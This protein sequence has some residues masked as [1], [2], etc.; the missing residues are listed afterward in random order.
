MSHSEH[1][2]LIQI[3]KL[4]EEGK[5]EKAL[6]LLNEFGK[7]E[8]L[9]HRERIAYYRLKSLVANYFLDRNECRKYA[10]KAYQESKKLENSLL[11]LDVYIQMGTALLWNFKTSEAS[12][13][14]KKSEDLLKTLPQEFSTELRKRKAYILW[15]K[16]IYY[17]QKGDLEKGIEYREDSLAILEE[18]DLKIDI[19]FVLFQLG[20]VSLQS[21]DFNHALEY[22]ES[23]EILFTNLNLI[24]FL[25]R[26]YQLYGFIYGMKGELDRAL[27]YNEKVMA[28]AEKEND[29]D[30]RLSMY[31]SSG[32]LYQQKGD[33][34]HALKFL[35]KSITIAEE[36]G[37]TSHKFAVNDSLFYLA[38]EMNDLEQAQ[39][40]LNRMK[41]IDDQEKNQTNSYNQLYNINKAIYLKNSPRALNRGKAEEML[42]QLIKEGIF[43]YEN[44]I[45]ALLNLCDLLLFE[46]RATSEPEILDE[47]QVYISQLFA[48]LKSSRSYSLLAETYLLQARL[49]L[50]TLDMTKARKLLTK[51][52][53]IADKYGL[54]RLAIKISNEHDNLLKRIDVWNRL[55]ETK[56]PLSERMDLA[57]PNEQMER[58]IRKRE[59]IVP[60]VSSES[61]VFL[62]IISEGGIPIFS[63][64]FE[65][66]QTFEDH[67]FGGFFTAINTFINEK[68]S[69][70]LDRVMFGEHTL[71]M[72]SCSPF[73][74]CYIFKGQSYSAQQR[75]GVFVDKIRNDIP[76]WETFTKFY[77]LNKEIQL[78]D[79]PTLEPLI[80]EIFEV[81]K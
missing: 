68:F 76:T 66:D 61:P 45:N 7:K 14:I 30:L 23:S 56:A 37:T 40:Y 27:S 75:V 38:L 44:L 31:N 12:K 78:T 57:L 1:K 62:L 10:E 55:K 8:D 70:G 3:E 41:Q 53:E 5:L 33:Y 9:S 34:D 54:N 59:I 18:L 50:I 60:E 51:A 52:Q 26:C 79:V 47:L 21:G 48:A 49:S 67:L 11:L 64:S 24:H 72:N 20:S 43:Y 39:R 4:L 80:R 15:H 46:L 29:L 74:V 69:E 28:F 71:L 17:R 42:K 65:K 77:Q 36:N 35:E 25:H 13:F 63:Q 19:G 6:Q 81:V 58:M 32:I 2:E 73:F 16:G 22:I